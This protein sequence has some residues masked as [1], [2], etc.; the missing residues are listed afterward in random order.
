MV[1]SY[2]YRRWIASFIVFAATALCV[3]FL[4]SWPQ[5]K[6]YSDYR[7]T[8]CYIVGNT[9]EVGDSVC[10]DPYVMSPFF[11]AVT[12]CCIARVI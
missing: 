12:R 6:V 1:T 8:S 3:F 11:A 9:T 4:I 2:Y 5:Y 10:T 7:Q